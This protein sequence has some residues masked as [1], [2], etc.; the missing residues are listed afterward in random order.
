[1]IRKSILIS[2][3]LFTTI[4]FGQTANQMNLKGKVKSIQ[5][6]HEKCPAIALAT[7]YLRK[8]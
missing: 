8:E 2:G 7:S 3:L 6:V 1:M 4:S 5:E